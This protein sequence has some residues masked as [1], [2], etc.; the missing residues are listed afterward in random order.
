MPDKHRIEYDEGKKEFDRTKRPED[1]CPSTC[2]TSSPC[3][4][5]WLASPFGCCFHVLKDCACCL[6]MFTVSAPLAPI[7][8]QSSNLNIQLSAPLA[9]CFQPPTFRLLSPVFCLLTPDF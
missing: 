5:D 2:L 9:S 4:G 1:K 7:N 8:S 6:A 3:A